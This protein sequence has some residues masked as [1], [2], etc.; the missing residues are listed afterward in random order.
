MALTPPTFVKIRTRPEDVTR[1]T[2]HRSPPL[3]F[4]AGWKPPSLVGIEKLTLRGATLTSM[5][6]PRIVR[7]DVRQ[8]LDNP[9]TITLDIWDKGRELLT[10]GLLDDKIRIVLGAQAFVMI[11]V[12]KNG[13]LLTLEFEDA[14]VAGLR[15]QTTPIKAERGTTSRI[16][17]VKRMLT[18]K[19]APKLRWVI[20][21]GAPGSIT[22]EKN[23]LALTE[24]E[25]RKP[26]PFQSTKVK[27]AQATQEQI[28]NIKVVLGYLYDEGATQEQLAI[29]T[30]VVTAESRWINNPGGTGSSV[31]LFQQIDGYKIPG[32][33]TNID[34]LDRRQAAE[35]F[36]VRLKAAMTA[37]PNQP[38]HIYGQAVQRSGAGKE[39]AGAANYG[40]W[41]DESKDTA[42][43]WNR[44][45]GGSKA[46]V[47]TSMYEFRRGGFGGE[48]E[49]S[50]ECL[51]RLA[52]E[53][54]YRRFI[55]EGIFYFLPDELLVGTGPRLVLSETSRGMLT[56]IDF[57]MDEGVDPQTCT[58]SIHTEEWYAPVGTCVETIDLGP[59]N[60]V[61]LVNATTGSLLRPDE[62]EI[63]LIR[64]RA[65][66][67]EPPN[68]S[69][70]DIA[71]SEGG[72]SA[73]TGEA[74]PSD[75]LVPLGSIQQSIV[76]E[77]RG[78]LGVPYRYGG[79]SHAGVDCSGFTKAVY[80]SV[81][82][83]T[84]RVSSQQY[85]DFPTSKNLNLILPGD[86]VFFN[87]PPEIPPGHTGIYLGG[88]DF[89]HAP[90][91]G[92]V[93]KITNLAAYL[94]QGATWYGF[95]RPWDPSAL[96]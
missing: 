81:G 72:R 96:A 54:Q 49:S 37:L 17:F 89:I 20:D 7:A 70:V 60:G 14:D 57:D 82:S 50:W 53:V 16:D 38:M 41:E 62:Q 61:W 6:G 67:T 76:D 92:D 18:E 42:S 25:K 69:T 12:A 51:G 58:F 5:L 19:G 84:S 91:T 35:A 85:R 64:P 45:Y 80:A 31:G 28:D 36:F 56:P 10:S 4:D 75:D 33:F 48:P 9:L 44:A 90:H 24:T 95:S 1:L 86:Q 8:T 55:V 43:A 52:D 3:P 27:G 2:K 79:N 77:A 21:A 83:T 78:W 23:P 66:L 29:T 32:G 34:R 40:P 59:G 87:W 30:M 63:E 73:G 47:A 22:V 71:D 15:T 93:V 39:S 88:G 11:R 26:G 74:V 13:D 68:D 46:E 65:V 94:K